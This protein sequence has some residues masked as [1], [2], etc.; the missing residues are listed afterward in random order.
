MIVY[1]D[2]CE[3]ST[4]D[5][6]LIDKQVVLFLDQTFQTTKRKR[7]P[8]K[9]SGGINKSSSHRT[10]NFDPFLMTK[11]DSAMK[12]GVFFNSSSQPVRQTIIADL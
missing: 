6:L 5:D 10:C 2:S 4:N 12:K 9:K 8:T 3:Q 11:I 7:E 1:L